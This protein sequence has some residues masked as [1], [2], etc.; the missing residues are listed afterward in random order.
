MS[1]LLGCGYATDKGADLH[2][3]SLD[4]AGHLAC[5]WSQRRGD[6]PSFLTRHGDTY[7]IGCEM[8]DCARI[9]AYKAGQAVMQEVA[10]ITV[11]GESGLCHLLDTPWGIVGSCYGSGGFFMVDHGLTR[12]IWHKHRGGDSRGH[13]AALWNDRLLLVDLG[14]DCVDLVTSGGEPI[15]CIG[16]PLGTQ[17]RQWL[18]TSHDR[19]MLVCEAGDCLIPMKAEHDALTAGDRIPLIAKGFPATACLAPDGTLTVPVRGSDHIVMLHGDKQALAPLRGQWPRYSA[20]VDDLL[21]ICMQRSHELQAYRRQGDRLALL[22]TY[23]LGG[24]SCVI[25]VD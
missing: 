9:A 4:G 10:A 16:F 8:P 17:P 12:V 6:S 21:L 18:W 15:S 3:L 2:L 5:L 11:P 7:Y 24:A 13:C 19:A 23:H 20:W 25:P 22:D 1:T 14:L